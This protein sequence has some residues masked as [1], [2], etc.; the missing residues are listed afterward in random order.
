MRPE[1][2]SPADWLEDAESDLAPAESTSERP[3]RRSH[4]C[5]HAQQAAEKAIKAVLVSRGADPPKMHNLGALLDLLPPEVAL[6]SAAEEVADLSRYAT[7]TR[8]P[9][10]YEQITEEHFGG[11]LRLAKSVVEWAR[12]VVRD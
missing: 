2:G 12:D 11:A 4:R 10:S 7:V 3:V 1:P 5:F 8:Y 9:G 6:P